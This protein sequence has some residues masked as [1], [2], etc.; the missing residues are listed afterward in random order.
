V[1]GS[2]TPDEIEAYLL[3]LDNQELIE[4]NNQE[5]SFVVKDEALLSNII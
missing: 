5:P 1:F 3:Q 2:E 4:E